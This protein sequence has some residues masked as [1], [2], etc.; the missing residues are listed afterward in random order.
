MVTFEKLDPVIHSRIRLSILSVLISVK[1]ADFAYLKDATGTTDGNLSTHLSKLEESGY[2][3]IKKSFKGKKPHTS[4]VI[5]DI[6]RSAFSN[7]VETLKE[8]IHIDIKE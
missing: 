8:F 4:C 3:E 2:I 1:E 6:G 7:Y 5:T